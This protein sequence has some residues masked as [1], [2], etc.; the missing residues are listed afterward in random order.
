[1]VAHVTGELAVHAQPAGAVTATDPVVGLDPT[2]ALAGE[3]LNVQA[4]AAACV[5]V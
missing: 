1:M 5:T 4:T 2:V 3:M